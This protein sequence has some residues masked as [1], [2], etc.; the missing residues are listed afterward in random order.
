[1][2]SSQKLVTFF[3]EGI[4]KHGEPAQGQRAA[5]N[6]KLIKA[7]LRKDGISV[8]KICR[9]KSPIFRSAKI[10]KT[11]IT[12]FTRQISTLTTAGIPLIR[13]LNVISREHRNLVMRELIDRL[14]ASIEQGNSIATALNEYPC[15]FSEL[16]RNLIMAGEHSGT[17]D[18]LFDRI[19]IYQEKT[20]ALIEKINKALYY[21]MAVML[22]AL[23]VAVVLLIFVMP[24]FQQLYTGFGT[25]LPSPTRLIIHLSELVQRFWWLLGFAIIGGNAGFL[26]ARRRSA[27]FATTIDKLLLQLPIVGQILEKS[28]VAK[29]A[30]TLA[31][32]F[33]AGMPLI[34]ALQVVAGATGNR[35]F[36]RAI[37]NIRE[38]ITT[39]QSLHAAIRQ[40]K[41]FSSMV[42]QMIAVG[43]ESG[44][45]EK[46]LNKI[47]D[48]FERDVDHIVE[49]LGSL[50]EPIIMVILGV[51]IGAFVIAMYL[52]I[53]KLGSIV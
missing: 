36:S 9:K 20:S 10:S 2:S 45:L 1:M 49:G 47:A 42:V 28:A 5:H 35:I 41:I 26:F 43:E 12:L 27:S 24:Q 34:S 48:I 50:L 21:P 32:T 23:L 30:R 53:F 13:A 40:T 31:T 33:A 15:Y 8:H 51:F 25:T 38:N 3:W 44:T 39:G 14:Q 7:I 16:Y 11:E 18:I 17:L 22:V 52:P 29:F 6:S 46:M 19:A 37:L 4:N